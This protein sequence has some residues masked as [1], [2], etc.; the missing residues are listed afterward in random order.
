[1]NVRLAPAVVLLL[2]G[3]LSAMGQ[4]SSVPNANPNISKTNVSVPAN[5]KPAAKS[6]APAAASQPATKAPGAV[7]TAAP[8]R[9][10]QAQPSQSQ[11]SQAQSSQSRASQ[12]HPSWWRYASPEATAIVGL[13]WANLSSSVFA[14][15]VSDELSPEGDLGFPDLP[16]LKQSGQILIS[17]P[18][19]L[20]IA[21][22]IFPFDL[23]KTQATKAAL[24]PVKYR[25]I[26]LWIAPGKDALSVA[27]LNETLIL[28]GKRKTLQ[29]SIDREM[30]GTHDVAGTESTISPL[31]RR[32]A[33]FTGTDLFV[34]ASHLPDPLAG[35]FI[36]IDL[37]SYD[38]DGSVNLRQG[39]QMDAN[40]Q[41]ATPDD[42]AASAGF[43]RQAIPQFP[44]V[45]RGLKVR[46]D[47]TTV[48]LSMDLTR[49][50]L[51]SSLRGGAKSESKTEAKPD[52][53][54]L[55]A[56]NAIPVITTKTP[57]AEPKR[58]TPKVA[59]QEHVKEIAKATANPGTLKAPEKPQPPLDQTRMVQTG[60]KQPAPKLI[61]RTGA[62]SSEEST[63][64]TAG[65]S[66]PSGTAVA[67][68]PK[69]IQLKPTESIIP[70]QSVT[71]RTP[72]LTAEATTAAPIPTSK[73]DGTAQASEATPQ[74]TPQTKVDAPKQRKVIRIYGLDDGVREIEM[75]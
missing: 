25:G 37:E 73:P 74:V 28:L 45:A 32:A 49:D 35:L 68:A 18:E 1:M 23:V 70:D 30:F 56:S 5:A 31:L 41:M 34:V 60:V 9:T 38:F 22:G 66:A 12:S 17:S 6:A 51:T 48:R 50:E 47:G 54:P 24:K 69:A 10:A 26:D 39:L 62:P 63:A 4:G 20:A 71:V 61:D 8:A 33:K 64:E 65:T 43:L 29:A 57:I 7:G 75:R 42:A 36:P 40:Y 67:T 59:G 21:A 14:T 46:E 72:I 44:M 27:Q 58:E 19:T 55:P 53:A 16:L 13:N 52:A 15:A 11:T 2:A 3:A